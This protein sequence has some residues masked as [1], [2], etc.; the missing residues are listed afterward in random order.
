MRQA[1]RLPSN[2][3]GNSK[4]LIELQYTFQ[5]SVNAV[6]GSQFFRDSVAFRVRDQRESGRKILPF[7]T[8]GRLASQIARTRPQQ[9]GFELRGWELLQCE[10]YPG[11]AHDN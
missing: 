1:F 10:G 2:W 6:L 11:S 7:T 9:L 3:I 8:D 5:S 4:P